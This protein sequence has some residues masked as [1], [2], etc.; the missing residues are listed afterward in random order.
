MSDRIYCAT[1]IK[2]RVELL[3]E[4]NNNPQGGVWGVPGDVYVCT[5]LA[6]L[7]PCADSLT[8]P[9]GTLFKKP[10]LNFINTIPLIELRNG[11]YQI[12]CGG[13]G[14]SPAAFIYL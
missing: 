5:R 10:F 13:A 14:R 4:I 1:F 6:Q 3:T 9:G 12:L 11:M 8:V 2:R 7:A